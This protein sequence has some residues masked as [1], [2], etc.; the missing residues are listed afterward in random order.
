MIRPLL[1]LVAG[2]LLPLS[3]APFGIWPLGPL[4]LALWFVLLMGDRGRGILIGWLY[5][6]GLYGV[7][8]S[9]VYFSIHDYGHASPVLAGFLVLIF[10]GGMALFP[11]LTG[12]LF[13]RL[14]RAPDSQAANEVQ[15]REWVRAAAWFVI[16]LIGFEWLLTWFLTGF[17]WLAAG[18]G[19]IDSPLSGFAPLGGVVLVSTMTAVSAMGFVL[20]GRTLWRGG[21]ARP[22]RN[23]R[24]GLW[25]AVALLPWLVGAGISRISWTEPG[26][27]KTA[28]LV[29]GNVA[30]TT[31]WE[32]DTR[33]P[34][35]RHYRTLT[36]P[37]WGADLI[38][39]PEAA[40]TVFDHQAAELLAVL[41]ERGK[42]TGSALVLGLPAV[43][44]HTDGTYD[45]L[46]TARGLGTA[47]GRYVKRRLVPFGEYVPFEE[48]L[49]GIIGFFD[50]P[51]SHSRPG[52]WNQAPIRVNGGRASMAICYEI[53]YPELVRE[54]VDVLLTISNDTWFGDSIGPWQ[55]LAIARMRALENGRWLLRATNN[56]ITAIVDDRGVVRARLPQ[57][58]AGVLPGE[59][60]RMEGRTPFNRLGPW[61]LY[62][63]LLV[64]AVGLL[65]TRRRRAGAASSGKK[66]GQ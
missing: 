30:Q 38:L 2:G 64:I 61:P 10:A 21:S 43:E 65:L 51:M 47:E 17:P 37:Y 46:N 60:R 5:G 50:L 20:A 29:Q 56:G 36:E 52:A 44:V 66:P 57:F 41:D 7:G 11:L 53:V 42:A 35:I 58:E 54:D 9:W 6:L 34:I 19:Q 15:Y 8:V 18:Y 33:L 59:Y 27:L 12:W 16:L 28:A 48:L 45:F 14:C 25:M 1:A 32:A 26:E 55:H 62:G 3:M 49:R 40:L 4:S 31:K 39:W 22:V 13:R 23:R 63:L 24:A